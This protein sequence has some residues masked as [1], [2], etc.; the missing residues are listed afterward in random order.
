VEYKTDY[1]VDFGSG[2][3]EVDWRNHCPESKGEAGEQL[4]LL[5]FLDISD[6]FKTRV[7]NRYILIGYD[8]PTPG[9]PITEGCDLICDP[10]NCSVL[11]VT[12]VTVVF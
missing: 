8:V 1:V 4:E 11:V 10:P 2:R 12:V 7:T 9:T 3:V 5:D 6:G